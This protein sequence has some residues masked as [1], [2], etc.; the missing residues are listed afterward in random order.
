MSTNI[1]FIC[2]A[3][4]D[5]SR[6]AEDH[7]SETHQTHHF[8]SAG[9]NKKICHQLG[10]SFISIE[11]LEWA[12]KIYAM[13]PKHQKAIEEVYGR[14]HSSKIIILHIKDIYKYGEKN[15]VA[16]LKMKVVFD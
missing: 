6:T 2:S 12:D 14:V 11:Q 16:I 9:T 15:L 10:T 1:L 13:E 5:R 3:N 7:F 8:D 4:K